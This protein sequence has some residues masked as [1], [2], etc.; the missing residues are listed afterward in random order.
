MFRLKAVCLCFTLLQSSKKLLIIFRPSENS[1]C[2]CRT[3]SHPQNLSVGQITFEEL[4]Y[5]VPAPLLEIFRFLR[6][7]RFL[8]QL[9]RPEKKIVYRHR[10]CDFI[11]A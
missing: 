8:H 4:G 6:I 3:F 9:A 1:K 11:A 7:F 2:K 10:L 5:D